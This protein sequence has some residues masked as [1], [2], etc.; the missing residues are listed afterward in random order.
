MNFDLLINAGIDVESAVKRFM[1]NEA[2]Y[3][4]MLR[5]FLDDRNY[6]NLVEAISLDNKAD[7]LAASHTLKGLCGNLSM[8]GLFKLFTE[9]V[10]LF[11]AEKW[12]EACGMMTEITAE[13]NATTDAIRAWLEIQ[14]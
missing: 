8:D 9:Q 2:L 12:D 5:K 7:A 10:V 3:A 14:Q 11:R 6:E 4:K 1:G 13:Y